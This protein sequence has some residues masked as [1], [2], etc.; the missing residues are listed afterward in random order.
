MVRVHDETGDSMR[1]I[2]MIQT[3]LVF[4]RGEAITNQVVMDRFFYG[5]LTQ[6]F[7]RLVV[8]RSG[9]QSKTTSKV[10]RT[11][12]ALTL[13]RNVIMSLVVLTNLPDCTVRPIDSSHT[14]FVCQGR[15]QNYLDPSH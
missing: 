10:D 1:V 5:S 14:P 3:Q 13:A 2:P 8:E 4:G 11:W 15:K 7:S 6:K 12:I 9:L